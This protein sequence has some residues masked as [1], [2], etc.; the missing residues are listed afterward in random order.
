MVI[1]LRSGFIWPGELVSQDFIARV[2]WARVE[3]VYPYW[4]SSVVTFPSFSP[5]TIPPA[6]AADLTIAKDS[7][8]TERS[9]ACFNSSNNCSA[10]RVS[11]FAIL[12]DKRSLDITDVTGDEL[13]FLEAVTDE[14]STGL[15]KTRVAEVLWIIPGRRHIKHAQ[16]ALAGYQTVPLDDD[17]WWRGGEDC[18]GRALMLAPRLGKAGKEIAEQ[19]SNRLFEAL[20]QEF[21]APSPMLAPIATLILEHRVVHSQA[22]DLPSRL[23][24]VGRDSERS[25]HILRARRCYELSMDA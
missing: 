24:K 15:V 10:E 8:A 13:D 7:S 2:T 19:L 16:A 12:K 4:Y 1:L 23:E 5:P 17:T 6:S 11:P 3:S 18:W 25:G 21:D 20:D 14:L 22:A 9:I